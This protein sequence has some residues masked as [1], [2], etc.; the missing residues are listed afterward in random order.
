MK[1]LWHN[2]TAGGLATIRREFTA[3]DGTKRI[4]VG[5]PNGIEYTLTEDQVGPEAYDRVMK[6][7]GDR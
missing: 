6:P 1:T 3:E 4:V 5:Y 7:K 2:G